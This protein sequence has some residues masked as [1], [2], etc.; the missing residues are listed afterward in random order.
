MNVISLW[1][2]A[3]N[4][5]TLLKMFSDQGVENLL[6]KR[7]GPNNNSKNQVYLAQDIADLNIPIGPV[8]TALGSSTKPRAGGPIFHSKVDWVW[9]TPHA[10]S[11]APHAQLIIY[12]QYPEVRLSGLLKSSPHAPRQLLSVSPTAPTRGQE[13]DR[14]LL[15][16]TGS[17]NR[18]YGMIVAKGSPAGRRFLDNLTDK[19]LNHFPIHA[20]KPTDDRESLV[21]E[22]KRIHEMDWLDAVQLSQSGNISPCNGPRCGGHTL[23]AHLGIALNGKAEP[24]FGVWEVK[25][26]GVAS[27]DRP[28]SGRI[29]LFTPEPDLGLYAKNGTDWFARNYGR[30]KPGGERWDFTGQHKVTGAANSTTGL[31]LRLIGYDASSSTILD[32][33]GY[34]G[35]FS[36]DDTLVSGWSFA[37]LLMHWQKKHAMA[38]YVPNIRS[39]VVPTTFRY[40][41]E[42]HLGQGTAFKIFLK[43]M[44]NQAIYYDPGIKSE[45]Q[46]NGKW[47]PKA[48]SQFRINV[49]MLDQLYNKF[50]RVNVYE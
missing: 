22:L 33:S 37:K 43:A 18:V 7:L 35:L 1:E 19:A 44:A 24:D 14:V 4:H 27:F 42:I 20:S 30:R 16:G 29:T 28:A 25:A 39:K 36:P 11:P 8:T 46:P 40:G 9:L 23:E 26:H 17:D 45:L 3:I 15:F 34:V 2:D 10:K 32:N 5:E 12:P 21:R 38:A 41:S 50:D 49:K 6:V 31:N 47:S 48:R 13:P